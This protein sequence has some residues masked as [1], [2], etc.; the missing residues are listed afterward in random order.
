MKEMLFKDVFIE[1]YKLQEV[2]NRRQAVEDALSIWTGGLFDACEGQ[3]REDN[4][5]TA[6]E[7][8][9]DC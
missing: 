3:T 7:A 5:N 9:K 1:C 4:I 8:V 2:K 6:S